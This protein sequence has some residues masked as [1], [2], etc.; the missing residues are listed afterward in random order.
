MDFN[1][2]SSYN[3]KSYPDV[4]PLLGNNYHIIDPFYQEEEDEESFFEKYSPLLRKT[5][6]ENERLLRNRSKNIKHNAIEPF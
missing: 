4:S 1:F 5:E 2:L 3:I 6:N